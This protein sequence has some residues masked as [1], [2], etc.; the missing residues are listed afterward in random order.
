MPG[1]HLL[2][3]A[4]RARKLVEN[5]EVMRKVLDDNGV[6]HRVIA[7]R[8]KAEC[9]E[10]GVPWMTN[11]AVDEQ[12]PAAVC[13]AKGSPRA[14]IDPEAYAR[15]DVERDEDEEGSVVAARE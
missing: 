13:G 4:V 1:K 6:V 2:R 8:S 9:L 7:G 10:Q 11:F 15:R 5:G 12:E 14:R 3:A